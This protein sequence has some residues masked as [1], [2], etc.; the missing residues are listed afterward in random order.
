MTIEPINESEMV[1]LDISSSGKVLPPKT[2]MIALIDA[3]TAIFGACLSSEY[4]VELLPRGFYTDEEWLEMTVT[5]ELTIFDEEAGVLYKLDLHAAMTKAIDKLQDMADNW[6]CKD[7][8]AHFTAGRMSFRYTQVTPTYKENRT[9]D[10]TKRAP[11]GLMALKKEIVKQ[12]PE[13]AF[14]WTEYEADDT[15]VAKK[16]AHPSKYLLC[17][18]DKDVLYTLPGTHLNYY[19]SSLYGI[20]PKLVEVDYWD[21]IKH[22]YVQTLTGDTGD[23]VIGLHR[24]GKKTAEKM[25][26]GAK[27]EAELWEKVVKAYESKGRDV[28]DAIINMRLVNMHQVTYK[29]GEF[30]L[31][32]WTPK[33]N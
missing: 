13:K 25:L 26:A 7:W 32:L 19:S 18:V 3:D 20:E 11:A 14:I 24:V 17:A 8:E 1:D 9:L 12:Y 23:N 2:E 4:E 27:T 21:A 6:A 10:S 29:D 5:D 15:V 31:E 30:S 16:K 33:E 28:I 22:H